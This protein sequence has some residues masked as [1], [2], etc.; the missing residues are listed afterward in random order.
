MLIQSF[1]AVAA[2]FSANA[3]LIQ[4]LAQP[5]ARTEAPR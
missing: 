1:T 3:I 2:G 4:R 5:Q